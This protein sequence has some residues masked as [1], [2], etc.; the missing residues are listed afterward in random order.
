[1]KL[2]S[3]VALTWAA[4]NCII[5]MTSGCARYTPES[6]RCE[7][8]STRYPF[9]GTK[10]V[11]RSY[12]Y[13]EVEE[14]P[15][16]IVDSIRVCD[17]RANNSRYDS[18]C[19]EVSRNVDRTHRVK[20]IYKEEYEHK[21]MRRISMNS[22]DK[23]RRDRYNTT[24]PEISRI[25]QAREPWEI[26][27]VGKV[28]GSATRPR[29]GSHSSRN[30]WEECSVHIDS[31][32][33]R[34]EYGDTTRSHMRV[35][36]PTVSMEWE[37]GFTYKWSE[38]GKAPR[39]IPKRTSRFITISTDLATRRVEIRSVAS[40]RRD[41]LEAIRRHQED[42]LSQI[43]KHIDD[44]LAVIQKHRADSMAVVQRHIDVIEHIKAAALAQVQHR[45]DSIAYIKA[46]ALAKIQ[47]RKDS[48]EHIK[49]ARIA[50]ARQKQKEL[51]QLREKQANTFTSVYAASLW[52]GATRWRQTYGRSTP[53]G[54]SKTLMIFRGGE[55]ACQ[56]PW[57]GN[58]S[59]GSYSINEVNGDEITIRVD[60]MGTFLVKRKSST[61]AIF[62]FFLAN[63]GFIGRG[64]ESDALM[65]SSECRGE[66]TAMDY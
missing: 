61:T 8:A 27:S 2:R 16:H 51:R 31:E 1:M 33:V 53:W 34:I 30:V 44:S 59:S 19:I 7:D 21:C 66:F 23:H 62:S 4:I 12:S 32:T 6:C 57:K 37:E 9:Q 63:P 52:L 14:L 41:S 64:L 22:V 54:T 43:Q 20:I 56:V 42:S 45:K 55:F 48:I 26:C 13:Q 46:L 39:T 35:V 24:S 5:C 36:P 10:R 28:F 17:E 49:E 15:T 47:H 58:S 60:G 50:A 18:L 29:G 3:S 38:Y 11:L 25:V 65:L 40:M